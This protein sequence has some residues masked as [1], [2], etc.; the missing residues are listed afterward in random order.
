MN[1]ITKVIIYILIFSI[2]VVIGWFAGKQFSTKEDKAINKDKTQ[3][4]KNTEYQEWMNYILK[5]D[6]NNITYYYQIIDENDSNFKMDVSSF[7]TNEL[8]KEDLKDIFDSMNNSS[9]G[10]VLGLGG[11]SNYIKINYNNNKSLTITEGALLFVENDQELK[12]ILSN[13]VKNIVSNMTD[14]EKELYGENPTGNV[15]RNWDGSKI[16]KYFN[17]SKAKVYY[18][19]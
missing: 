5:Q 12:N 6:I 15:I 18:S 10:L 14:E 4:E 11:T 1:K 3:I 19:E 9:I 7:Y 8:S 2:S 13:E 17:K 16:N